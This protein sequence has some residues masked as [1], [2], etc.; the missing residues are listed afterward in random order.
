MGF[1]SVFPIHVFLSPVYI[2]GHGD[3]NEKTALSAQDSSPYSCPRF[4]WPMVKT[5]FPG[6]KNNRPRGRAF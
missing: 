1:L 5:A 4:F 3:K 6:D 2:R